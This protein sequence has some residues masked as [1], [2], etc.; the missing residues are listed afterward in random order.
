MVLVEGLVFGGSLRPVV[1]VAT[2]TPEA[3]Y[4]MSSRHTIQ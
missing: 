4:L 1:A 2:W 3:R